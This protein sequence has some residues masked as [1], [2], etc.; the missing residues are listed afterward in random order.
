MVAVGVPKLSF[1]ND[2]SNSCAFLSVLTS[3]KL[4]SCSNTEA[5]LQL[6]DFWSKLAEAV[7]DIILTSQISFNPL[8]DITQHYDVMEAANI[9]KIAGLVHPKL[10]FEEKILTTYGAFSKEGKNDLSNVIRK[11]YESCTAN[12]P[13]V[14]IYTGYPIWM[15]VCHRDAPYS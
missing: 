6:T 10:E 14:G 11:L 2:A 13:T 7:N 1:N 15:H 3:N 8:R 5:N 9:L 12:L 4:I